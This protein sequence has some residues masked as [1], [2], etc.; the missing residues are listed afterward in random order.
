MGVSCYNLSRV[1]YVHNGTLLFAFGLVF[2]L[3][4]HHFTIAEFS[5]LL[6]LSLTEDGVSVD[7]D[8][9]KSGLNLMLSIVALRLLRTFTLFCYISSFGP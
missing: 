7:R 8:H 6:V 3:H 4:K 5:A 1:Y 2:G 9:A